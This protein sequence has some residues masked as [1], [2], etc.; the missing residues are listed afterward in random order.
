MSKSLRDYT[1]LTAKVN[2]TEQN[3]R[4]ISAGQISRSRSTG[5]LRLLLVCTFVLTLFLAL[6]SKSYAQP[7]DFPGPDWFFDS[8][9]LLN[10]FGQ[11]QPIGPP[12]GP[13]QP[14][15]GPPAFPGA[16]P[17]EYLYISLDNVTGGNRYT[18]SSLSLSG[19]V[20][21]IL[22]ETGTARST[23]WWVGTNDLADPNLGGTALSIT[24]SGEVRRL[25]QLT[26]QGN[27][28]NS[29]EIFY[30]G[31]YDYLTTLYLTNPRNPSG[32]LG[33]TVM[34][35]ATNNAGGV[36]RDS[37]ILDVSRK[38]TNAPNT[39]A[40]GRAEINGLYNINVGSLEN[41]G[42]IS[43]QTGTGHLGTMYI[44]VSNDLINGINA[45]VVGGEVR[46]R[47][48]AEII[49]E[50]YYGSD[51][52]PS[53]Y[54]TGIYVGGNLIQWFDGS[55]RARGGSID[56]LGELYNAG[57]IRIND[58]LSG[59]LSSNWFIR[60]N[61][62][63]NDGRSWAQWSMTRGLYTSSAVSNTVPDNGAWG[64][65]YDAQIS[66]LSDLTNIG[67]NA[68][69]DGTVNTNLN[70]RYLA[71]EAAAIDTINSMHVGGTLYNL[72]RAS[73]LN[74]NNIV[75]HEDLVNR[76]ALVVGGSWSRHSNITDRYEHVQHIQVGRID[77]W[78]NVYNTTEDT[79]VAYNG[80]S[81]VGAPGYLDQLYGGKIASFD[82]F[83]IH[84]S[85]YND[86]NS[87]I[88]GSYIH[89]GT[90]PF[91]DDGAKSPYTIYGRRASVIGGVML[92]GEYHDAPTHLNVMGIFYNSEPG[93]TPFYGVFNE[94]H[95]REIDIISVGAN[96]SG[97]LWNALTPPI[98]RLITLADGTPIGTPGMIT[99]IGVINT[100]NLYNSGTISDIDVGVNVSYMFFNDETGILDGFSTTHME[101]QYDEFGVP[102][103][104]MGSW[105]PG[106][107][108]DDPPI[109]VEGE[110]PIVLQDTRSALR[111]GRA[112]AGNPLNVYLGESVTDIGIINHGVI[113]NF[114]TVSTLGHLYNFGNM[115]VEVDVD[116]TGRMVGGITSITVG[117]NVNDASRAD[118][119]NHGILQN[120]DS[121]SVTRNLYLEEG[122]VFENVG[123][124][125]AQ[126]DVWVRGNI[127]GGF[128][129]LNAKDGQLNITGAWQT[130]I[131]GRR[132]IDP[133]TGYPMLTEDSASLT[134]DGGAVAS[135]NTSIQVDGYVVNNGLLSSSMGIVNRGIIQ[136]NG[137]ISAFNTFHNQGLM[138]GNGMVSLSSS[139]G[140]FENSNSGIINGG[141]TISG[142]FRNNGG[143]IIVREATDIIR[144][145]NNGTATLVGGVIDV[146]YTNP[147]VGTQYM[148]MATDKPGNLH[149]TQAFRGFG[150]GETG[151]VLDFTPV[152][153][154][155][156]GS[157][158]VAGQQWAQNNQ[159]YWLEFQR[160]YSYGAHA[161][162]PNQVA[163]GHYIDTISSAPVR[164]GG[165]WN[166]LVQLD[167]IS[168]DPT[169]PH[170]H[171]D[172]KAHQGKIN[173]AALRA[174]DELGGGGLY[175]SI[176]IASAHN[177]GVVNRSLADA[178]RSDVFKFSHIGNP[179]NAIR[180]QAIAP[181]RFTRW[182]T[183][184]G[185]G[186]SSSSDGNADG[187]TQSFGGVLAGIDRALW[188]GTRIG[189]W[190]SV[191]DGDVSMKNLNE[192]SGITN[193][194]VGMYMRQEMYFGYGLVSAGFG[195]DTYKNRRELTMTGHRAQ[196]KFTGGI[197]TVYM[198]RGIDI[199][200]YYA[201]LQPYTSFQVAH[202]SQEKFTEKMWDHTGQ[203]S[204][205]GL[206]GLKGTTE[207]Y[208]MSIGARMSSA[209]VTMRWGQVA[210]TMNSAWFHDFSDKKGRDFVGRFTNPGGSNF[211]TQFSDATF[212]VAGNDPKQD[213]FNFGFGL[214]MDRNSTRVFLG[215]DMFTNSRQTLVSGFGGVAT[216]W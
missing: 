149:V 168:D 74:Y 205:I 110:R 14:P 18:S 50:Y 30:I 109:F 6:P 11:W 108:E 119:Q 203:Y 211:G 141:L 17:Y 152:F 92:G 127:D 28:S 19:S 35:N 104:D 144:A 156:D 82:V 100:T 212:R 9:P 45:S 61:S 34:G 93:E 57:E 216:A 124:L 197:G 99:D 31:G 33:I 134:I 164:D 90:G 196:S 15:A 187:Y 171:P 10:P 79:F 178:L 107:E 70:V 160:A 193:I 98:A 133:E 12:Y 132:L 89:N 95:I 112:T 184:F 185:I 159:Y 125:T 120:V 199:P 39:A 71:S 208:L 136:N 122:S 36:I 210:L 182:G 204:S 32:Y 215:A 29:G 7:H 115:G 123:T 179:N 137:M 81:T 56:V 72:D 189:G 121:V 150:S 169:N 102:I 73:L 175:A 135:A 49:S 147:V 181:L 206:E 186:G 139:T 116:G 55:I 65:I 170:F 91:G 40:A 202:I 20:R 53:S 180:G 172:Y 80:S 128:R 60:A 201:T 87:M 143:T 191:A 4:L 16:A 13:G 157:K 190:F 111:V 63:Y 106:E 200:I 44:T 117:S 174:L 66:T 129:V 105:I 101:W 76:G 118:M 130:D 54:S 173:P 78:N 166:L 22:N 167:G 161:V 58:N 209:P 38:L 177:I 158:Y 59:A 77:I 8:D 153:G 214:N 138:T 64:I 3:T 84:G 145:A 103:I 24:G 165:L 88:T 96:E 46:T 207:S 27:L 67:V 21:G 86:P 192:K 126:N 183:L 140:V 97:L 43:S 151:S 142:N 154:Y 37:Y 213:W 83:N 51:S 48:S 41:Y 155:W 146:Q 188:T 163:I 176:G 47:R 23:H 42:L 131:A 52:P 198:E 148:F 69:I 85:L 94:G 195:G 114:E 26:V 5:G 25:M 113:T 1:I 2:S 68:V 162:T 75:I 194:M 62:I